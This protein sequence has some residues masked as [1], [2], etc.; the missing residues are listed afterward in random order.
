MKETL[1]RYKPTLVSISSSEERTWFVC[2]TKY[3]G[4]APWWLH[5]FID[6]LWGHVFIV[7]QLG[8]N[9]LIM[10]PN[11][12]GTELDMKFCEEGGVLSAEFVAD[13]MHDIGASV[14]KFTHVPDVLK[15]STVW[16]PSCVTAV[17][18]V[19]G[20]NSNALTP[21]QL[22]TALCKKGAMLYT[23]TKKV[24]D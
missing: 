3:D 11:K 20:F 17:K 19:M 4:N 15:L 22:V 24:I 10:N 12:K 13:A 18:S 5:P 16:A 23:P 8:N 1:A 21:R 2:F 9:V 14:L 6:P 7:C